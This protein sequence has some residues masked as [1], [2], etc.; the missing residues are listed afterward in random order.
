V[1]EVEIVEVVRSG[2]SRAALVSSTN[3]PGP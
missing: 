3:F 1:G 2:S